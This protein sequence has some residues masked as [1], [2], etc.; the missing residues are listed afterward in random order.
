VTH[1]DHLVV[2]SDLRHRT[3]VLVAAA[4]LGLLALVLL[5]ALVISRGAH[6]YAMT[7]AE[8]R[9]R[10]GSDLLDVVGRDMPDLTAAAV[11]RGLSTAEDTQLDRAIG[12]GRREGLLSDL[13]VWDPSGRVVYSGDSLRHPGTRPPLETDVTA[14]THGAD[15]VVAHPRE[16]DLS[17]G[18]HTG[19]LD[20]FQPLR[21]DHGRLYGAVETTLPLR[22][23]L[24]DATHNTRR[25]LTILFASAALL[26]LALLPI[27][28]RAARGLAA[29]WAPKR[30]RTLRAFKRALANDEI[31]LVYQ[32]QVDPRTGAVHALEALVRWR[33]GGRLEAPGTFLP[34]IETSPLM[35]ELTD[36]VI[37]L[38]L[39]QLSALLDAGHRMRMSVN[40]SAANLGDLSLPSRIAAALARHGVP[41]ASLTVEV[42]ETAV[43]EDPALAQRVVNAIADLAVEVAVDDFGTGHASISRLHQLPVREV[44]IDRSFVSSTDD[45]SRSYVAAIVRFVS[46]LG[47]RVVAEG[48]EDLETM[49]FL[50]ALECDLVQG[51]HVSRPLEPD[52]LAIWLGEHDPQALLPAAA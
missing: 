46:D 17:T 9:A 6:G 7:A 31:E 40:L 2:L 10:L 49:R 21:D 3:R 26:W 8:Q 34:T 16:L 51:Y 30:R 28:V 25:L 22:P 43:L 42:T 33:R 52:G 18:R 23:I 38:A 12:R 4:T 50:E 1:G 19:V 44:K 41:G 32:P 35:P 39:A 13:T 29:Q 48:V 37:E 47:L 20:S 11:S 5:I 36:R 27:L 14:A 15:V 24:Q 45:R